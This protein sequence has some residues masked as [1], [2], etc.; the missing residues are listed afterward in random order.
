MLAQKTRYALRS[1]LYLFEEGDGAPVQLAKI[2]KT[3]QVPPKYLELIMLDLKRAGMV[4][5]VRGPKGGY[6][7]ARDPSEI[8]FGDIVRVMEGP[9]AL[10]P[11]ASVN[12]YA[13]CGDCHDEASCAIR[14]AFAMVRDESA[15]VL[16]GISL[17]SAAEWEEFP[18]TE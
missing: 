5:S 6:A 1:L 17:R 15:R 9:I 18:A 7:L 11:C 10:V 2:A 14:R 4:R 8:S 3:Q 13:R 12:F 16:E